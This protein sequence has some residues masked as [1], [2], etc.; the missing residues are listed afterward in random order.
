MIQV[1]IKQKGNNILEYLKDVK[2]SYNDKITTDY[3]INGIISIV[4]LSMR[5][6]LCKPDYIYDKFKSQRK[7]K[8]QILLV[9]V[10][11]LNYEKC[12]EELFF[13]S[14]EYNFTMILSFSNEEAGKYIKSFSQQKN[15]NLI[16]KKSYTNEEKITEFFTSFP[17][18]NKSDAKQIIN[19]NKS[20]YD[21]FKNMENI[22]SITGIGKKKIDSLNEYLD[23]KFDE[24]E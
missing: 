19:N 20:I 22:K 24:F 2:W 14:N 18:I 9:L 21:F 17:K 23:K 4:F 6:H 10:D 11:V 8:T 13:I 7:Y 15:I 5:F 3:E 16:R 12:S 1:S